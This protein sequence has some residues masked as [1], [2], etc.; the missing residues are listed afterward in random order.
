VTPESLDPGGPGIILN[1]AGEGEV[2]DAIDINSLIFPL[3][4]PEQWVRSGRFIQADIT[5]LPVRSNVAAE[6]LG[7][8]LPMM[9]N[10]DRF[11]VVREAARV[12]VPGGAL[13]LHASS[14]GGAIWLPIFEA[15]GLEAST[16]EGI[17]AVGVKPR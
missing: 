9:S 11:A 6:V 13:R 2:D 12:L 8:K 1:L 15:V 10:D 14:G 17:H 5:A 7:R 3:R 16:L 4:H